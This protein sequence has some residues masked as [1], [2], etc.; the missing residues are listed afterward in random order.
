MSVQRTPVI[1]RIRRHE[2]WLILALGLVLALLLRLTVFNAESLDLT[3]FVFP[4]Y[5]TI[6]RSGGFLALKENIGDYTPPYLYLLAVAAYLHDW[7][8]RIYGIKLISITFDFVSGLFAYKLVRLRYPTGSAPLIA[9]LVLLFAPT[10]VLNSAYWGQVDAAYTAGLLACLY[11][12]LKKRE[13]LAFIAFGLALAFKLQAIFFAPVLVILWLKQQ[14]AWKSF[15]LV[16]LVY[17]ITII[18]AWLIGRPLPELLSIYLRTA[19][20]YPELTVSAPNFYQWFPADE[21]SRSLL[22]PAALMFAVAVA[23]LLI[24]VAYK[25]RVPIAGGSLIE[26]ALVS[27]LLLPFFLPR[28]HE[29]YFFPADVLA[30][31]YAFYY[32]RLFFVPIG[33]GL[34]SFFAYA[35]FLFELT[36]IPLPMLALA[37][38]GMLVLVTAHFVWSL[39]QQQQALH[40]PTV[41]SPKLA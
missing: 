41:P 24:V 6:R 16:P 40:P 15:L 10:V 34:I 25:I 20:G 1:S 27:L 19:E 9:L 33:I 12:L 17:L 22:T 35:P 32:P 30:I 2:D 29:R 5:H 11:F 3:T 4:W 21:A 7:I 31:V 23:F 36:V 18:P 28:M 37:E 8:P 39:L 14:V 13:S 26:L 38:L